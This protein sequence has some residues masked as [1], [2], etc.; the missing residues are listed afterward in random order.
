MGEV[1]AKDIETRTEMSSNVIFLNSRI[2]RAVI[3]GKKIIDWCTSNSYSLLFCTL[4]LITLA[5]VF[6]VG[7]MQ[8]E[9]LGLYQ[10]SSVKADTN[11][12]GR[13]DQKEWGKVYQ[14][15]GIHFDVYTSNPESD[16]TRE[17]LKQ[18]L[19]R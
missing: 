18:Y 11:G 7:S 3:S 15:L 8:R 5:G 4:G 19:S 2:R 6:T 16:L 12:D 9:H 14:Q 1:M 17:K 10:Q 13:T